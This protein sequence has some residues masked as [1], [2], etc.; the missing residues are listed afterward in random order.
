MSDS[1]LFLASE[2]KQKQV[3][4]FLDQLMK[5]VKLTEIPK[6]SKKNPIY[7]LGKRQ[8]YRNSFFISVYA[9]AFFYSIASYFDIIAQ[10]HTINRDSHKRI[11]FTNW[12]EYQSKNNKSDD[13]IR[14]L[15]SEMEDWVR[16]VIFIRNNFAHRCHPI[17]HSEMVVVKKEQ[18]FYTIKIMPIKF[19]NTMYSIDDLCVKINENFNRIIQKFV[20]N[21]NRRYTYL[22]KVEKDIF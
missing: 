22:S 4:Y 19:Q 16:E 1:S 12:I 18:S 9:D 14:F 3:Q 2:W 8:I 15:K 5:H 17:S 13:Y 21:R 7:L 10:Y 6:T 11:S 20:K